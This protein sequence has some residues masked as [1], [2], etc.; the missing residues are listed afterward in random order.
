MG[1]NCL[2]V[3]R[4]CRKLAAMLFTHTTQRGIL[5]HALEGSGEPVGLL[6]S[7]AQPWVLMSTPPSTPPTPLSTCL[8]KYGPASPHLYLRKGDN[9]VSGGRTRL[10]HGPGVDLTD[11]IW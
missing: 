8:R 10:W 4:A 5:Y 2:T 1:A 11:A 9:V 7:Q 3:K 6:A